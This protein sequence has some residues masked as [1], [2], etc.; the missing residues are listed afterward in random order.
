LLLSWDQFD[1]AF[2]AASLKV[3]FSAAGPTVVKPT[4]VRHTRLICAHL[5]Q[6]RL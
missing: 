1:A 6:Q 3:L 5:R 2:P 4:P